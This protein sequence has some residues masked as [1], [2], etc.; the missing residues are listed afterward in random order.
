MVCKMVR[1]SKPSPAE[2]VAFAKRYAEQM[3]DEDSKTFALFDS[4]ANKKIAVTARATNAS[5]SRLRENEGG[6]PR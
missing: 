2:K 5:L 3:T 6:G 1:T 4:S